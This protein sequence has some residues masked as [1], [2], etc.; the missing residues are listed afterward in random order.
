MIDDFIQQIH[1]Q[2]LIPNENYCCGTKLKQN[3]NK[4]KQLYLPLQAWFF[5]HDVA[6]KYSKQEP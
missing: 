5:W 2:H 3:K 6:C 4:S 1:A